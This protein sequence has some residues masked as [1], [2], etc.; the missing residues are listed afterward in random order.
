M[1]QPSGFFDY[2]LLAGLAALGVFLVS[3]LATA[4]YFNSKHHYEQRM[5]NG[6]PTP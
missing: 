3:R 1:C 5:K 2:L 6:R 4:A